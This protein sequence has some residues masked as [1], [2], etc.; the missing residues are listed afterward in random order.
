MSIQFSWGTLSASN[1]RSGLHLQIQQIF[2]LNCQYR[3][4]IDRIVS[5]L[6]EA[7]MPDNH[8]LPHMHTNT[9][10]ASCAAKLL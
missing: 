10:P 8:T 2:Q 5:A 9:F 7:S 4:E 6:S 1:I 3:S